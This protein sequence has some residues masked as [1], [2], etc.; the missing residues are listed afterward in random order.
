MF[1]TEK[2]LFALTEKYLFARAQ[3]LLVFRF[4]SKPLASSYQAT[5]LDMPIQCIFWKPGEMLLGNHQQVNDNLFSSEF[6]A[7]PS[8]AA[9]FAGFRLLSV[10][11]YLYDC[12]SILRF[13]INIVYYYYYII[14]SQNWNDHILNKIEQKKAFTFQNF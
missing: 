2:F 8:A 4:S 12:S 7:S 6:Q 10:I 3:K 9:C 14:T 13:I 1:L 11:R 5:R